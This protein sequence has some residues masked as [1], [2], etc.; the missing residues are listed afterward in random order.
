MLSAGYI[1]Y[2]NNNVIHG[3]GHTVDEAWRCVLADL[4]RPLDLDGNPVDDET[5]FE[6]FHVRPATHELLD[7]IILRGGDLLWDND[8]Y[9]AD[10]YW[11]EEPYII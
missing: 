10:I 6:M 4:D 11:G 1:I 3:S 2:D 9:V 8:G 5:W 7:V